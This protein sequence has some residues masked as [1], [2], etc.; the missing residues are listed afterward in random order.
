M[1]VK[2]DENTPMSLARAFV[3]RGHDCSH[4]LEEGL[5]GSTDADLFRVCVDEG[6]LLVTLDRGFGDVRLYPPGTHHGIVVLR[7]HGQSAAMVVSLVGS[8]LEEHELTE[9]ARA[10]VVVDE[11]VVRIRRD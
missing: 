3:V 10:N 4:A 6:R 1:K 7:P 9:F 5:G 2:L 8:L 11:V